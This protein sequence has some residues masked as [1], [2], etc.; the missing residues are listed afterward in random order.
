M[1]LIVINQNSINTEIECA[2]Y[3]VRSCFVID[4]PVDLPRISPFMQVL[5]Q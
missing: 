5:S 3:T 4:N 2:Q 1:Y